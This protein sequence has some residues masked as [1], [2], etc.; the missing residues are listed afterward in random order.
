M[1]IDSKIAP[2]VD[3]NF[4]VMRDNAR[5][6]MAGQVIDYLTT[7][8]ILLMGWSPY[9]RDLKPTEHLWNHVK[10]KC[11]D[12]QLIIINWWMK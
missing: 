6:N 11:V 12:F 4:S 8:S 5:P 1:K 9:S 2:F 7:V 10:K 3:P